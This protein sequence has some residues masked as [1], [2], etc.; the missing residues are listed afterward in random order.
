MRL[1]QPALLP[2]VLSLL[3]PLGLSAGQP[4]NDLIQQGAPFDDQY[5]PEEALKYYLPAE[6]LEPGNVDL[7]LR[8]ARQYRHLMQDSTDLQ[9]QLRHGATA[10]D[11][12]ARAIALAPNNADTH[13]SLAICHVKMVPILGTKERMEASRQIKASVDKAIQLNP[14]DDLAWHILGCWHQKLADISVLKRAIAKVVYGSIPAAS[15]E[16]SVRCLE[17]AIQLNPSRPMHHIELG[18]T[19]AQM[20]KSEDAKR[21]IEKG[22]SLPD[23]GKDDP[24]QKRRGRETLAVLR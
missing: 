7:L 22:L 9:E 1:P 15:N 16:E 19:Y 3:A 14:N 12:A 13:L 10:K 20:G 6:K 4:A 24:E 11:Y 8:I 18:R 23:V 21:H 5:Q 17:K 2:L